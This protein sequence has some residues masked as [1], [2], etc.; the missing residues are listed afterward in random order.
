MSYMN[1]NIIDALGYLMYVKQGDFW[2]FQ[3][4]L[5]SKFQK[6]ESLDRWVARTM[7]RWAVKWEK[8]HVPRHIFFPFAVGLHY[9]VIY[10]D[11]HRD[12]VVYVDPLDPNTHAT[13]QS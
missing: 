7:K 3:S 12:R 10:W 4:L 8:G 5:Y 1:D 6:G 2:I 13:D 11:T 9:R